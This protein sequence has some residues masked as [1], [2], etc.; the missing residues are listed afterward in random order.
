MTYTSIF[1]SCSNIYLRRNTLIIDQNIFHL[2]NKSNHVYKMITAFKK[3]KKKWQKL[4][5]LSLSHQIGQQK[6]KQIKPRYTS[7]SRSSVSPT[8]KQSCLSLLF[9][10]PSLRKSPAQILLSCF[11]YTIRKTKKTGLSSFSP[12][13]SSLFL[14]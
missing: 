2:M 11:F 3:T 12:L 9:L 10:F 5:D 8:K 6:R 1:I 7:P 13:D 14:T 4:S